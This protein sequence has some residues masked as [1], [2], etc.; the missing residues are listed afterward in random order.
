M[1]A[2]VHLL[3]VV[4]LMAMGVIDVANGK[5]PESKTPLEE[6]VSNVGGLLC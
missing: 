5:L 6:K 2:L 3:V 4:M 1:G